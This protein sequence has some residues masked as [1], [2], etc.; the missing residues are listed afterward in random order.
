MRA[1]L[2][3]D[4]YRLQPQASPSQKHCLWHLP[5]VWSVTVYRW[6]AIQPQKPRKSG[7][8]GTTNDRKKS[9]V[10]SLD[11]AAGQAENSRAFGPYWTAPQL[12]RQ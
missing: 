4:L 12:R 6:F 9:V 11:D 7:S 5:L 10:V 1:A 2:A 8:D 3:A